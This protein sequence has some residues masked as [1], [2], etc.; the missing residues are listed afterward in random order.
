MQSRFRVLIQQFRMSYLCSLSWCLWL[1]AP[2]LLLSA[3]N[4]LAPASYVVGGTGMNP[5]EHELDEMKT[6]VFVD[7][8]KNVLPRTVLRVNLSEDISLLLLELELVPGTVDPGDAMAMVRSRERNG[9]IMSIESIARD[10]GVKQVLFIEMESFGQLQRSADLRPNAS[11]LIRV[12]HFGQGGRV[13]PTG[14]IEDPDGG[15]RRVS[16]QLR[17]VAPSQMRSTADRRRI[18]ASV[19]QQLAANVT[20][21]FYKHDARDLGENL[22]IR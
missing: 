12:M 10:A 14:D 8:R 4:I 1:L 22:G 19:I 5:A 3:C 17:E 20:K 13:Y 21:L 7:D 11:C 18:E 16:V 6:L 9:Q 15:T 2:V